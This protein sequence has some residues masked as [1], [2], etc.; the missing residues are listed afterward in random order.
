MYFFLE[1]E[2]G[3]V[4]HIAKGGGGEFKDGDFTGDNSLDKVYLI[5]TAGFRR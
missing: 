3:V 5:I 2:V 4:N 1:L